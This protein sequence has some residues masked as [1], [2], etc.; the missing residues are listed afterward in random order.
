MIETT[1]TNS[2]AQVDHGT[3]TQ[4]LA[5]NTL[6]K[7]KAKQ[8]IGGVRIICD[9]IYYVAQISQKDASG[10]EVL[11]LTTSDESITEIED[12]LK[13]KLAKSDKVRF[14][15]FTE[16]ISESV[17]K[18]FKN[19]RLLKEKK[20][21]EVISILG[22]KVDISYSKL[23]I[24]V[25]QLSAVTIKSL[26]HMN[27][28]EVMVRYGL[29]KE[30]ALEVKKVIDNVF[31]IPYC[32]II[33]EAIKLPFIFADLAQYKFIFVSNFHN[34]REAEAKFIAKLSV[35]KHLTILAND[36]TK[37]KPKQFE[38]NWEFISSAYKRE[39]VKEICLTDDQ[40]ANPA[41]SQ[42]REKDKPKSLIDEILQNKISTSNIEELV[43]VILKV[44]S[45]KRAN[46]P[47]LQLIS[48]IPGFDNVFLS[49]FCK[50]VSGENNSVYDFLVKYQD[51]LSDKTKAKLLPVLKYLSTIENKLDK[52]NANSIMIHLLNLFR[53]VGI[54]TQATEEM[55]NQLVD[56]HLWLKFLQNNEDLR[57]SDDL[58]ECYIANGS[59]RSKPK[60]GQFSQA[61][62][63]KSMEATINFKFPV[64]I[65][66]KSP[67]TPKGGP[68]PEVKIEDVPIR[69][70][71]ATR[72]KPR[73]C[74][75]HAGTI[76]N[77]ARKIR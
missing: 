66:M 10:E 53:A 34:L 50:L 54:D 60:T 71:N 26:K 46:L 65:T 9:R 30:A 58:I 22:E 8:G 17:S 28:Y 73:P 27:E 29:E 48:L 37:A 61:K 45:N 31:Y 69:R 77:A 15:T 5:C 2:F 14:V 21:K 67:L 25:Q 11:V 43:E 40:T 1:N 68:S 7:I 12:Q 56:L 44:L 23:K 52:K 38:K 13:P 20:I 33:E 57:V 32:Q 35:G 3:V 75:W 59:L 42:E 74:S 47:F 36:S 62:D 18:H 6:L 51:S 24:S 72:Y 70:S 39:N 76:A 4:H 41:D 55:K 19:W 64:S 49:K 63:G 16:L